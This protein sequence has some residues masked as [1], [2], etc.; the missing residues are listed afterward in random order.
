MSLLDDATCAALDGVWVPT[1]F[2]PVASEPIML[3]DSD[4]VSRGALITEECR[5]RREREIVASFAAL[6]RVFREALYRQMREAFP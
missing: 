2:A 4:L 5:S 3:R 1:S 6:D